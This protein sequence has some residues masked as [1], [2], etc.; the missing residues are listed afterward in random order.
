MS[1]LQIVVIAGTSRN[2]TAC[3][4]AG[5]GAIDGKEGSS[6]RVRWRASSSSLQ[7]RLSSSLRHRRR[8]IV[9][10]PG[11]CRGAGR[12]PS[13]EET[14]CLLSSR[15]RRT[16]ADRDRYAGDLPRGSRYVAVT[17]RGGKRVKTTHDTK[18]EARRARDRR[19]ASGIAPSRE[20]VRG[21]RRALA[22]RVPRPHR[23]WPGDL[24]PRGVRVDDADLR[25]AVLPRHA[26]RRHRPRRRQALHR[27][28]RR[29]PGTPPAE[30]RP[31]P[32][33][34]DDPTRS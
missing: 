31:A 33:R 22:D 28:P 12:A 29:D 17:Y 34:L 14:S 19:A 10:A 1:H 30:R 3:G 20:R 23:A 16:G 25:R 13:A 26:D 24:D 18:A 7:R 8:P 5:N 21:L 15:P 6:V 4:L 2:L 27:P 32:Q 9:Q 11:C